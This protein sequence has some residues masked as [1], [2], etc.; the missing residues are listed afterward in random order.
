MPLIKVILLITSL[1]LFVSFS[2][3][4]S[5]QSHKQSEEHNVTSPD[6]LNIEK[7]LALI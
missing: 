7:K 3:A 2:W 4:N 1:F 6:A 5:E